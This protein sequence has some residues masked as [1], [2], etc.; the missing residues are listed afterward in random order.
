MGRTG[1]IDEERVHR[2]SGS[3]ESAPPGHHA[4][5]PRRTGG[6]H[7]AAPGDDRRGRHDRDRRA[8]E[9]RRGGGRGRGRARLGHPERRGR[10]R[11]PGH[12]PG[13]LP[14]PG[15]RH[16]GRPRT[17]P[18]PLHAPARGLLARGRGHGR[19]PV[20]PRPGTAAGRRASPRPSRPPS[21]T[22]SPR[23]TSTTPPPSAS[24]S[25]SWRTTAT[26]S[27][28]PMPSP[29][30]PGV[31]RAASRFVAGVVRG[32]STQEWRPVAVVVR[33]WRGIRRCARTAP[34]PPAQ[35]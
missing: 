27:T 3:G 13:T 25:S 29:P 16:E 21:R 1:H 12:R 26:P 8:V 18:T 33:P 4:A 11:A 15:A 17:A 23:S 7:L 35:E 10:M 20:A 31:P 9:R 32:G 2:G 34:P 5:G 19:A 22:P 30:D 14:E 6:T 24:P 28:S